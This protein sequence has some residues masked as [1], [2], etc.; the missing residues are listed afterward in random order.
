MTYMNQDDPS[1]TVSPQSVPDLV[2]KLFRDVSQLF[3]TEAELI[4]SEM[5]D[6]VSQLQVGLGK[7][8][9]GAIILLV[10]LIVL[11]DSLVQAIANII[12]RASSTPA[13]Q[14]AADTLNANQGWAR[15]HRRRHLRR[16]RRVPRALGHHR[17]QRAQPHPR[18][19]RAAGQA[20]HRACQGAD[21]M[22]RETA[23]IER[24][25][26]AQRYEVEETLE[27][28]RTKLSTGEILN[29]V[30]RTFTGAG[31]QGNEFVSNLGRQVKENP[32]PIA[33][34]G[35]GLVWL[36]MNQNQGQGQGRAST[37]RYDP[38]RC[39]RRLRPRPRRHRRRPDVSVARVDRH[40]LRQGA[41]R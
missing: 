15:A 27:A 37:G 32:L 13:A 1:H 30:A 31:Q 5:G 18:P 33:L 40:L 29:S 22:S 11:A 35:I 19:H 16:H 21:P 25:V 8:A 36:L 12:T 28:L 9:A 14:S 6:K 3:R 17:P 7:I 10:A 2:T 41:L 38:V 24:D 4:R 26:E 34:T 39:P 20:R 23:E